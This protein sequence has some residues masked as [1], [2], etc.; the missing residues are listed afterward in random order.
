MGDD[1][2]RHDR[3]QRMRKISNVLW[4]AAVLALILWLLVGQQLPNGIS[5]ALGAFG[6]L[7]AMLA[8]ALRINSRYRP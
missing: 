2:E 4:V 7:M 8:M 3:S 1:L 5:V 6:P